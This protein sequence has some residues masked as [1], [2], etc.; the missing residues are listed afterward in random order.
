MFVLF[1]HKDK[2]YQDLAR[3]ESELWGRSKSAERTCWFDS[4]TVC[5]YIN[6]SISGRPDVDW[7]EYVKQ[8]YLS[9]P[10]ARGL[11][12]GCGHGELERMIVRRNLVQHMDGVDISAGAV[13]QATTLA[14]QE[15]LADRVLY[16]VGDANDLDRSLPQAQY[17]V[18]FVSMALH[19][20]AHLEKSLY[21]V[22]S[23]LKPKGLFIVNEFIGPDRFQWTE[24]QLDAANRILA[25]FPSEIKAN[26]REPGK[27]ITRVT[28]PSL[29]YMKENF[30]FEAICSER[31]V[32]ALY[33]KFH[34][35]EQKNYGGTI[36]H[37][38]FEAIMG[39][40]KEETNREHAILVRMACVMEKLL[41]DQG[42]LQHDHA[43]LICK[44]K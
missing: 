7:L 29:K 33:D 20:F 38:L 26:L 32:P 4:P 36:L 19:H 15:G 37:L 24:A 9:R 30:A 21:S 43:L 23:M 11:N 31:I 18:V 41:L 12:L 44:R 28:R 10:A 22:Q 39:N 16:R 2:S 25:C 35:I 1:D 8:R 17:D 5:R 13:A 42:V 40:F 34:I 6:Q 14:A 27:K 3:Q